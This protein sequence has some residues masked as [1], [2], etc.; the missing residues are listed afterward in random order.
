[1]SPFK[2]L[3]LHSSYLSF[4]TV[5]LNYTVHRRRRETD[6]VINTKCR[7]RRET[8]R[9]G[10]CVCVRARKTGPVWGLNYQT[11]VPRKLQLTDSNTS[12]QIYRQ[13]ANMR[14][15]N[16]KRRLTSLRN[17]KLLSETCHHLYTLHFIWGFTSRYRGL[18]IQYAQLTL[19]SLTHLTT[20][21]Q[22]T[23]LCRWFQSYVWY[24]ITYFFKILKFKDPI[25]WVVCFNVLTCFL[26]K[27][28]V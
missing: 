10:E 6:G 2:T 18:A 12:S 26:L 1:M 25:W 24:K 20:C 21:T 23:L 9:Q 15:W 28:E 4:L 3:P 17:I 19:I 14:E 27:Q 11:S 22:F 16:T 5:T 7:E 13:R 8:D